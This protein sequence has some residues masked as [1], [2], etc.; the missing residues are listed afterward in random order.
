MYDVYTQE[1]CADD[2][3][4]EDVKLFFLPA[5]N[6]EVTM[7]AKIGDQTKTFTVTAAGANGLLQEA[8]DG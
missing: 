7:T 4:K 5:A 1:E 2:P 3:E 8:Y 6:T